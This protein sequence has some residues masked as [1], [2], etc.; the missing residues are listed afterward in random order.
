[1][2]TAG[3]V[4]NVLLLTVPLAVGL[5]YAAT[6]LVTLVAGHSYEEA[7]TI[8]TLL[9]PMLVLIASYGVL[10]N[11]QVALDHVSLL[12]RILAAAVVAKIAINL[13]VIPAYGPKGAA[14]VA[15]SV[16]ACVVVVQWWMARTY[17]EVRS[18]LGFVARIFAAGAVMAGVA[19]GVG[20]FAPWPVALVA[21]G[22]AFGA[23]TIVL[24]CVDP[25]ELRMVRAA[26]R[27]GIT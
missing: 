20:A 23:A 25:G 8:L 14:I 9:C 18:L 26:F 19:L 27:G 13:V 16:E 12:V 1:M 3:A 10:A 24:R 22:A 15:S 4:R 17:V 7:G 2:Q 5:A 6:P 21:A 11:L